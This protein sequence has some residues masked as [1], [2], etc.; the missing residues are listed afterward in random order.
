MV[1][2]ILILI[3]KQLN[4]IKLKLLHIGQLIHINITISR[5]N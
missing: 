1:I 2:N 4:E 3:K 5:L